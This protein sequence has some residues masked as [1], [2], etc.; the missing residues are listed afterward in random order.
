[1]KIN[2]NRIAREEILGE[3][4]IA[5]SKE[6]HGVGLNDLCSQM[7]FSA[8][9]PHRSLVVLFFAIHVHVC[10][11]EHICKRCGLLGG[12]HAE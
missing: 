10:F 1:M 8:Y 12:A 5:F 7:W 9:L 3:L 4:Y 6:D 2:S 11:F